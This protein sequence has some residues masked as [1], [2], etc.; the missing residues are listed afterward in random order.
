MNVRKIVTK[1]NETMAIAQLED[2]HGS[3]NVV[4][5]PRTYAAHPEI[6]REDAI[7]IVSGKVDVGR[8]ESNGDDESHGV[9]E[10]LIDSAEEWSPG[11]DEALDEVPEL[12]EQG[13]PELIEWATADAVGVREDAPMY[14]AD[15]S[16][17]PSVEGDGPVTWGDEGEPSA[18]PGSHEDTAP[19]ASAQV[20]EALRL[21]AFSFRETTDRASDLERLRRL[22]AAIQ[23][24]TGDD[25]YV[26]RFVG[27]GETK[28]LV[29]DTL[30][31]HY[32]KE[33]EREVEEI[34]GA[35]AIGVER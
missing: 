19:P 5:F 26:I 27:D 8:M 7:L 15:A 1:K 16:L 29:G 2:L 23:R 11:E 28:Q 32:S 4:A 10:V 18:G 3:L 34:L 14:V 31:V 12:L 13:P 21:V 33:L 24:R 6:W 35:G 17:S 30:R 20:R 22:Y 9:P 25:R